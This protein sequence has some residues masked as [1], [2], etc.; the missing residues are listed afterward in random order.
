MSAPLEWDALWS[1]MR[2]EPH[3]WIDTTAS[4]FDDM[5]GAVPPQDMAAGGFLVGEPN[6]STPQG[7]DVY[8]C[9]VS[10]GGFQAR[11]MTQREF[12]SWKSIRG[13]P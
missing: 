10:R 8:A 11:Y 7:E 9:F 3:R 12:N 13:T 4:M 5:L 6:H 1:A 2:P